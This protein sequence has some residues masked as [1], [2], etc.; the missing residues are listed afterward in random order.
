L[1]RTHFFAKIDS[2][3]RLQHF[4]KFFF[5]RSWK[6]VINWLSARFLAR[7]RN[8]KTLIISV[9]QNITEVL[10]LV[11]PRFTSNPLGNRA[12]VIKLRHGSTYTRFDF[13]QRIALH[14][15]RRLFLW[16]QS[17]RLTNN[18]IFFTPFEDVLSFPFRIACWDNQGVEKGSV[19]APNA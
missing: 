11:T 14:C 12:G 7:A 19:T 3:F 13:A 4:G 17:M 9:L 18:R 1:L 8:D 15:L 6:I 5:T 10:R 16:K 2:F